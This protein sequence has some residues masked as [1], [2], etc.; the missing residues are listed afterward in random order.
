ML[1]REFGGSSSDGLMDLEEGRDPFYEVDIDLVSELQAPLLGIAANARVA[2]SK[3]GDDTSKVLEYLQAIEFSSQNL[4]KLVD[5][6]LKSRD[7]DSQSLAL[8]T[9]PIHLGIKVEEAIDKLEPLCRVQAQVFDFRPNK[10]LVVSANMECLDL[11]VY[12]ILEQALRS[13]AGEEIVSVK[14]SARAGLARISIHAKGSRE[15]ASMLRAALKRTNGRKLGV[16]FSLVASYRLLRSMGGSLNIS[17]R[18]DGISFNFNLPLSKQGDL[19]G[20]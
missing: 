12:H 13:S 14:L 5:I 4:V 3:I 6:L 10:S 16:N 2:R 8:E 18:R 15:K 19:F 20:V 1:E 11:V 9:A 7:V 17:Q